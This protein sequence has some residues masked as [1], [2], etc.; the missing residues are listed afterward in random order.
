MTKLGF[1]GR[2][3]QP[4]D[5]QL[6][7]L[8]KQ[9]CEGDYAE[10]H[11]GACLGADAAAHEAADDCGIPTIVHPPTNARYRMPYDP[12]ALWLP[13]RP[14][15]DRNRD[16]VDATDILIALPDGPER[17]QSGTWATIR[18]ATK[19]GRVAEICYPNGDVYYR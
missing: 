17:Q 10:L 1:T 12:R 4:T 13:A 8:Y 11:H 15:L 9:L 7:W 19:I 2:R 14:Y 18:Y 6:D 5:E 3:T 16:I